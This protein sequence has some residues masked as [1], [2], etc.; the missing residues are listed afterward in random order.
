LIG[1]IFFLSGKINKK[2][3]QSLHLKQCSFKLSLLLRRTKQKPKGMIESGSKK[4][5]KCDFFILK[6]H[7]ASK[8][9]F[10]FKTAKIS[11]KLLNPIK[12]LLKIYISKLMVDVV[13]V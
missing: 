4:P 6:Y 3:F 2:C 13:N 5:L 12:Y 11:N 1:E 8:T 10:N 9:E 7:T